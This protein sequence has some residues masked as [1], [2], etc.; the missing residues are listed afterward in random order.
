MRY[1]SFVQ[2]QE[3][4]LCIT[5]L[6]HTVGN[7]LTH[8]LPH[9]SAFSASV[10]AFVYSGMYVALNEVKIAAAAVGATAGLN[11]WCLFPSSYL[12]LFQTLVEVAET[13]SSCSQWVTSQT[14]NRNLD[15]V[16]GFFFKYGLF[17]GSF[18]SKAALKSETFL[19]CSLMAALVF[20]F[21]QTLSWHPA[22]TILLSGVFL[23]FLL[24]SPGCF[25][26]KESELLKW[27]TGHLLQKEGLLS[28]VFYSVPSAL[29]WVPSPCL[30]HS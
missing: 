26:K 12:F 20:T 19:F 22:S 8:E 25:D 9:S 18:H 2:L 7:I 24:S 16:I 28:V 5:A 11:I 30:Y 14:W 6:Y 27:I 1:S 4:F 13:A 29:S 15:A 17:Q 23:F 3:R 21:L 10:K